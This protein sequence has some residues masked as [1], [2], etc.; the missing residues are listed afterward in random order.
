MGEDVLI[1]IFA[2]KADLLEDKD[3]AD[4][5]E[6]QVTEEEIKQLQEQKNIQ[7]IYTSAKTGKNVDESFIAMTKKLIHKKSQGG[8]E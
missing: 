7:V 8:G 5:E 6:I 3:T 4:N 2:N 1:F